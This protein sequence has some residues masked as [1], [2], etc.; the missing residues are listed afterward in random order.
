M[1]RVPFHKASVIAAST[2][3][4]GSGTSP[5]ADSLRWRMTKG[6]IQREFPGVQ[7][8]T[9]GELAAILEAAG[10]A[11]PLLLD[12]RTAAEFEVSHL[13]GALRVNTDDLQ[14]RLDAPKETPI[15][16]Y[17]SVGY[18]SAKMAQRLHAAGFTNVR[19]LEGSLFQW[20]NEGR[21]FVSSAA[22]RG[23]VHPYNGWAGMLLSANLRA[24]VPA[25][26]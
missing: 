15:V 16:T 1:A 12:V 5:A 26:N 21:P 4:L 2:V 7:A 6:K 10:R 23:K 11:K 8:I 3:L 14:V 18:R 17:C 22:H 25:A 19:N 9:T 20:A 24:K 13:R